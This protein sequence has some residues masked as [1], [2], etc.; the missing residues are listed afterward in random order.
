MNEQRVFCLDSNV[1]IEG[2]KY[3]SLRRVPDYW[4]ILDN[5]GKKGVVLAPIEVLREIEKIDDDLKTWCFQRKHMFRDITT[6]IQVELRKIMKTYPRLVDSTRQRS[7]ADPWVIAFAI[8]HKAT[9]VTKETPI[10][11]DG[12]RIKIPDVCAA[13]GVTCIDDFEFADL[14]GLR[15]KATLD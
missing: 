8:I 5:L 7:V 9:V 4:D 3:W 14:I 11:P 13:L 1:F 2:N 12:R 10:G 6:E 15:F